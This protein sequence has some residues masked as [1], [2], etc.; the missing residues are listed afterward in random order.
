MPDI[1]SFQFNEK[2]L[3]LFGFA[4]KA[5]AV[6]SGY[7][8]LKRAVMK[9]RVGVIIIIGKI[10]EHNFQ[11]VRRLSQ[12]YKVPVF[13]ARE[14]E[15]FRKATGYTNQKLFGIYHGELARGFLN[16]LRQEIQ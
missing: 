11:R 12:K 13:L 4:K 8:A 5:R 2:L 10:G 16:I 7:E 3:T 15:K 1:N 14:D 9:R 6:A